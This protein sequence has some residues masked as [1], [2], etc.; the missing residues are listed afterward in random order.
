[1][2]NAVKFLS[3]TDDAYT[4]GGYGVVFG[5]TD[6]DGETFQQN[7]DYMLDL[8]P[9]KPVLYDHMM[10]DVKTPVGTVA[11][12]KADDDGLWIEAEISRAN[13]Y[14]E[15]IMAL[16]HA[17]KLGWSSGSVQHMTQREGG[18][19]KSW[20]IVEFSLTPTPAEPRTL[21]VRELKSLVDELPELGHVLPA[22]GAPESAAVQQ[23]AP[24]TVDVN[25]NI[26]S[27][28]GDKM[29]E[30][31]EVQAQPVPQ[32]NSAV[33][34]A[35]K[36]L[37][38]KLDTV[39]AEV[40]AFQATD[41]KKAVNDPGVAP[42]VIAD[43]SHWKYDNLENEDLGVMI[44]VLDA[45]KQGNRSK[46]GPSAAAYKALAMRLEG[47]EAQKTEAG[48]TAAGAMKSAGIKANEIAQSTL[49][50]YGD[51]WAG[52]YYSGALW[53]KVRAETP[54]LGRVPEMEVPA[55]AESV[56]I[57]LE[58]ADPSWY[59]VAQASALSSDPGGIPTNTVTSSKM[60]TGNQ[61]MTLAKMG[62]RVL[63]TGELEEDAVLPYVA[64]LRRQLSQSAAETLE[65]VLIDG[66]TDL[67][68]S[69]NINNIAGTPAATAIY[70][71]WNGF[72]KLPLVTLTANSRD[73]GALDI[74]D[75]LETI[76]L[77]GTGGISGYDQQRVAFIVDR[78][79]HYKA[80]E[81]PEVKTRD[82][83]GGATLEGGRLTGIW[84][85]PVYMSGHMAKVTNG[86]TN[87]AGKSDLNTAGNNTKGQILAVRW[88]R[89][90]FGWRRRMTIETNRIAAADSTEIVALMRAGLTYSA[91][92]DA[93]AISYNL[94]V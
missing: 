47:E 48:R 86:L 55:G 60:G 4:V 51:E 69:T 16:V 45:A 1:M 7:T 8:V 31:Q 58:G 22:E 30:N 26:H 24:A 94:T 5:S 29:E 27:H 3:A 37:A 82:V 64:Q 21:G 12:L 54:I 53:E 66:D 44:G 57:P 92:D 76:K 59:K 19:I 74:N 41:D 62:A 2:T 39:Q 35:I 73:G 38:G 68:A 67:T 91:A 63:W 15:R 28:G 72:R 18:V 34:D 50:T 80:L 17:G 11:D 93:A 10:R 88:D 40:K 33:L 43:T 20:P 36:A 32:D 87:T 46:R 89:W 70:A 42:A 6:L 77:M 78:A 56:V 14:A 85:Y 71:M 79:T 9:R 81:L 90:M 23:P 65:S 49:S 61:T 25:I 13:Q 75:F 52:V 84:G 83:F